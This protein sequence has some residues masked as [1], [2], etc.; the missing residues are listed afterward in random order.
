LHYAAGLGFGSLVLPLL[1]RGAEL[2]R[3]DDEGK[4]PLEVA[5]DARHDDI[6]DVLR[7]RGAK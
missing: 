1:E 3:R 7:S 2:S 6:A 4:T 5:I